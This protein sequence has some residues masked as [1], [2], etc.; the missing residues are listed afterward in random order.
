[1][2]GNIYAADGSL[3]ATSLPRYDVHVDMLAAGMNKQLFTQ[4]LDSLSE[5]LSE[6]FKD[7]SAKQYKQQLKQARKDGERYYLLKRNI[8][9]SEKK[10]LFT[11]PLFKQGKNKSGLIITQLS[12]REKPFKFLASR[13]IGYCIDNKEVMPVGIEGSFDKN[14]KGIKGK[15]LM[16]RIAG[17]VWKPVNTENEIEPKDG[18]DVITTIDLNLQDVAENALLKQLTAQDA[19]M[20]CAILMEVA[21]GDIKAI[22][23]LKRMGTEDNHFYSEEYNLAIAQATEPGSTFKLM[24]LMAAMEDGYVDLNNLVDTK[25]GILPIGSNKY[26]RDSHPGLYGIIPVKKAFA[27]SSN[28]GIASVIM[29]YYSGRPQTFI[30]RIKSMHVAD[31]YPL[32][33]NGQASARIKNFKDKD[34]SGIS[35][36]YIA[37]GYESRLTPLQQLTF[38]NAVANNGKMVKPHFVKEIRSK[39]QLVKSFPVEVIAD[40]ICSASTISKARQLL[41][42]V[43][44]T[45]TGSDI[46]N[47][48][49]SI[50][51]KTGTA[52]IAQGANGYKNGQIKYQASFCGYFP[53]DHPQ[54]SCIVIVYEPGK[55]SYYGGSVAC[56]VFKEISDK[57]Y[58]LNIKMHDE[59]KRVPDSLFSGLPSIKAGRSTQTAFVMNDLKIKQ[60]IPSTVWHNTNMS[61]Y[62]PI[63]DA[64]PNVIG[65]GLR[66]AIYLLESQGLTVKPIGRGAVKK[67][68]ISAGAKIQK[69]QQ[70]I[71]ELG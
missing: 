56:P 2:R 52:Q 18:S 34:W 45:G 71:I 51:G 7:K 32:Q 25:G 57:V 35:L 67:Q 29:K 8:S 1:M 66:D 59:M 54:Y 44:L 23:N 13:T 48:E 22:A 65:M 68:S 53:A 62:T 19:E 46:R 28:A 27:V 24:S 63:E 9:Y 47:K 39:G 3:L 43:V 49:Y 64:V 30:D 15:R 69:G 70:I 60:N 10:Q 36:P 4:G 5:C 6:L 61:A 17:N 58:A 33:L 16:Q 26:I 11:F 55:D 50:A 40:S 41:E 21:T 37:I 20:G 42:E 14:L 38:Y 31:N 12:K